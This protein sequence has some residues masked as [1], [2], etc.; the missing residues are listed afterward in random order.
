M[1]E[2]KKGGQRV[3]EMRSA[4]SNDWTEFEVLTSNPHG[5]GLD[6]RVLVRT[7]NAA[8]FLDLAIEEYTGRTR[9][10]KYVGVRLEEEAARKMYAVLVE[11]FGG[12]G[13]RLVAAAP[14]LLAELD[15]SI[16]REYNPFEPDNQ[17][18]RYKKLIALRSKA[19]G[20]A[21]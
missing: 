7:K 16:D 4:I 11:K 8:P 17:S 13:E 19:T 9:R 2:A 3:A 20:S 12:A 6:S 1:T 18:D 5:E 15:R 21:T 14:D 10:A